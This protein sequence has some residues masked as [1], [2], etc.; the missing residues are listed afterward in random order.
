MYIRMTDGRDRGEV[1]EMVDEEARAM[2]AS[3]KALAVDFQQPDP[4]GTRVDF[5]EMVKEDSFSIGG[6]TA[7]VTDIV[8]PRTAEVI[9]P[10]RS[11]EAHLRKPARDNPA[12]RRRS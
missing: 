1:I 8:P 2:L 5:D 3:G 6:L 9:P 7:A 4:L 12:R 11:L 10:V